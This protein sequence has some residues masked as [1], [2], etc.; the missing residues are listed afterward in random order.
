MVLEQWIVQGG[1]AADVRVFEAISR[2][3]AGEQPRYGALDAVVLVP[4][5]ELVPNPEQG[6]VAGAICVAGAVEEDNIF[7]P[8]SLA[9]DLAVHPGP[10]LGVAVVVTL[11][12][13]A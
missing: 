13:S 10:L 7:A 12:L 1:V 3:T 4:V 11:G 9:D 2:E 5:D 8:T 6:A